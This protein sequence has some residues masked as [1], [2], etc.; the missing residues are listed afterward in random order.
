[1]IVLGL[2]TRVTS[3]FARFLGSF[4]LAPPM[5][6]PV[7]EHD[8]QAFERIARLQEKVRGVLTA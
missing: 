5:H 3:D 2:M 8:G 4:V 7:T 6:R 1:M